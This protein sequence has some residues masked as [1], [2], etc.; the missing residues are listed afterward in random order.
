MLTRQKL[1][2]EADLPDMGEIVA[3]GRA[4]ARDWRVGK[5]AFLVER[6]VASEVEYKQQQITAGRITQ[7][8]NIG[9]RDLERTCRA[10]AEVWEACEKHGAAIARYGVSLD[11]SM[12]LPR[13]Q[14]AKGM[15]GTGL[16]LDGPEDFA[17]L[18]SSAPVAPHFGDW[19][20]GFPAAIENTCAALAAGSTSI[21]NLSQYFTF[22]PPGW[23]DDVMMTER[24][25]T[26]IALIAAQPEP[27]M[28]HSNLD[29]G[30]GGLFADVSSTLGMAIL[31]QRI[32]ND[33]L[34]ARVAHCYGN[35]FGD[36]MRRLAF[37]F[38][39]AEIDELPG[40][41]V[42]GSTV[43]YR[44]GE[45]SNYAGLASYLTVDM[46]G[47]AVSPTGH[48][49]NPVPATENVR[50][51]DI[52]EII[53][54]Q[55]F[56]GRLFEFKETYT[57]LI[58]VAPA[59]A[60]A[61]QMVEGGRRFVA[62]VTTGLAN[63]GIDTDNP[64]ELLLALRRLG[65]SRVEELFGAGTPDREK[66]RGRK[67]VVQSSLVEDLYAI[68]DSRL[69]KVPKPL[70]ERVR[71]ERPSV[72]VACTDVH[73]HGKIA[74]EAVLKRLG[75]EVLDGGVSVDADDLAQAALAQNASAIMISTYNG[76]ALDFYRS[77]RAALG[78]PIPILIGG[79][80][81]QVPKGSNT[82]LPV[83]VTSELQAEGALVCREI[84]DAVP[85]LVS[86]APRDRPSA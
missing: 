7:H 43:S 20:L 82:S 72:M 15:K 22:R 27:V 84:E 11:W 16:I 21:G 37:L 42:N 56:A 38:A 31:E 17:R 66:L 40:T 6:K 33:L 12:G 10:W 34:G 14:R 45:G 68:A 86:R 50:I 26:A 63:A 44:G 65:A 64:F 30:F 23:D 67:P 49:L 52:E 83:D 2:P 18:T 60:L 73:E 41:M 3:R 4:L 46:V 1:L 85:H 78:K 51:P 75:V 39:L 77:L 53:E 47:Q 55:L 81:N 19:A 13:D 59:K 79:R 28:V 29:D 57:Q 80:L 62:A 32:V 69:A 54:A 36:P 48:A 70:A 9:Y 24:T 8:A 71:D 35:H 5:S 76:I 61:A 25:L 58:D 74:L